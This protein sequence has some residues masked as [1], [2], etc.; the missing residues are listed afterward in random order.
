[1]RTMYPVLELSI[2]S[3]TAAIFR[4]MINSPRVTAFRTQ[5]ERGVTPLMS[6]LEI[7]SIIRF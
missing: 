5:S 3:F 2:S 6:I 4:A 7:S 1:M